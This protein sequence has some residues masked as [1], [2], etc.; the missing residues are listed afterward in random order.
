LFVISH[1]NGTPLQA[2][3]LDSRLCPSSDIRHWLG[4]G[5]QHRTNRGRY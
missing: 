1:D 4:V 5:E 2:F 3:S